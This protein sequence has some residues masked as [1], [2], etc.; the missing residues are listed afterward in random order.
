MIVGRDLVAVGQAGVRCA[1]GLEGADAEC[2][3]SAGGRQSVLCTIYV[4]NTY[5]SKN[6]DALPRP[7]RVSFE[8]SSS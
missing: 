1:V 7:Q 5:F 8:V 2:P 3:V 6:K 4:D